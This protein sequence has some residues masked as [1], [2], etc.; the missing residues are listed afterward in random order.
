MEKG[1]F[2]DWLRHYNNNLLRLKVEEGERLRSSLKVS[3]WSKKGHEIEDKAVLLLD[4]KTKSS[5]Q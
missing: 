3:K 4:K 2:M 1:S 5:L